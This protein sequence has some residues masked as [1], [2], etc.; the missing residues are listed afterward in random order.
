V[1]GRGEG[2]VT[3]GDAV[4]ALRHP[5][6]IN[7]EPVVG[8]LAPLNTEGSEVVRFKPG[9]DPSNPDQITM[10]TDARFDGLLLG[11]SVGVPLT[12]T[13]RLYGR[14]GLIWTHVQTGD[15]HVE[16]YDVGGIKLGWSELPLGQEGPLFFAGPAL[17]VIFRESPVLAVSADVEVLYF[18][19]AVSGAAT[20]P[21]GATHSI[22]AKDLVGN[23][24]PWGA[25]TLRIPIRLYPTRTIGISVSPIATSTLGGSWRCLGVGLQLGPSLEF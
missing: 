12:G 23:V 11:V 1:T 18:P 25:I 17:R 2:S 21:P 5:W 9:R 4:Q 8:Y 19:D 22:A 10:K 15:V 16:F 14:S 6:R 20:M 7:V 3:A 24:V 13:I